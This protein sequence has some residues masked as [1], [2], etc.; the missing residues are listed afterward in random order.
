[1]FIDISKL[2]IYVR[3]GVTDMRKQAAGL[4][5][6]VHESLKL[7]PFSGSLFLFCNRRRN[8]LKI[9]YWEKS[10]YCIWSKKLEEHRYPWPR[11]RGDAAE[12]TEQ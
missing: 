6:L 10:G 2:R 12:I 8:I 1:M 5:I 9:L 4:S 11:N 3:P 7:D